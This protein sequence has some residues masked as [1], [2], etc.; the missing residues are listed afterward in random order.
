VSTVSDNTGSV[1]CFG[2]YLD[3]PSGGYQPGQ[4]VE[5]EYRQFNIVPLS[6]LIPEYEDITRQMNM[7]IE[8]KCN[9]CKD[10]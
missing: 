2:Q 8:G 4:L 6:I 10:K 3:L 7:I 1:A 5:Y 9:S